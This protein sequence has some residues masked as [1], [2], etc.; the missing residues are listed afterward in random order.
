MEVKEELN[1][2]FQKTFTL[3]FGECNVT[4]DELKDYMLRDYYPVVR[5]RSALS[6]KEVIVSTENYPKDAKFLAQGEIDFS[7]EFK[8]NINELKDLDSVIEALSDRFYYAGSKSF[9]NSSFIEG[10]DN[11]TDSFYVLD[12]HN[13]LRSKYV[14]YSSYIRDNCE[15]IFGSSLF[16]RCKHLIRV[17]GADNL[18]RSF[19]SEFAVNSSDL[20]FSTSC[21]GSSHIMFSANQISKHHVIGN[22]ELQKDKY[23]ELRK[24]LIDESREYIEKNKRFYSLFEFPP[25]NKLTLPKI[26]V[27]KKSKAPTDFR[28]IDEAFKTTCKLIFGRE[29]GSLKNYEKLLEKR[30]TKIRTIKTAFGNETPFAPL[31]YWR[32][33]PKE[34]AVNAE[35]ALELAKEHILLEEGE[36]LS[37]KKLMEKLARIFFFRVHYYEGNNENNIETP[38]AYTGVN[39]Y[40]VFDMTYSKNGAYCNHPSHCEYIFGCSKITYSKFCINCHDSVNLSSCFEMDGCTNCSNSLFCHN[41][42]GLTDCLFCFN[43]KSKRYA[44]GNVEVGKEKY[45]K[46]KKLVL[47]ELAN[48][49][50]KNGELDFDIYEL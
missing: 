24:K 17:S 7:K 25:P 48:K 10:S 42:E 45:E 36:E 22:L 16:L 4:L 35:E 40:R 13:V 39:S 43:T 38:C 34:R 44:V 26:N 37:L 27:P 20:F 47:D 31:Y 23:F 11:C 14:A 9:G 29:I 15:Y 28:K 19:E 12:S 50:Q 21:V 49:L 32:H 8:L 30:V 18:V 5:R 3:I 46:I 33:V 41:C 2:A 1:K 6:G